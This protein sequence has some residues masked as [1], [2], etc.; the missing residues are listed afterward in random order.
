M[1]ERE[2][3][4]VLEEC[5]DLQKCKSRD[6]QNEKS[7]VKQAMHYRRGVSTI[8]D[9]V[10]QKLLRAQSLL[11]AYENGDISEPNFEGLEDTYKDAINYLSFAV[12]YLRGRME[13][14][15]SSRNMLNRIKECLP[16]KKIDGCS[17]T[18]SN[19]MSQYNVLTNDTSGGSSS[20]QV[21]DI[22]DD[23]F[24]TIHP[25][26]PIESKIKREYREKVLP[27][28]EIKLPEGEVNVTDRVQVSYVKEV[29]PRHIL[30]DIGSR[31]DKD[32]ESHRSSIKHQGL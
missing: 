12:S 3:V 2:S 20:G 9:M 32:E 25:Q 23:G 6:Y 22:E 17:G 14:Q 21:N 11:E 15:E 4:R 29:N 13:G 28:G 24:T 10:A 7:N 31:M 18:A 1:S 16:P 27:V 26:L 8:H 19:I 30:G 5:I